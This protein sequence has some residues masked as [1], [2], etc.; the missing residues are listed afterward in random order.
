MCKSYR[1]MMRNADAFVVTLLSQA[2]G[3]RAFSRERLRIVEEKI[4][5]SWGKERNIRMSG[6]M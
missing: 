3:T 5:V 2:S 1:M 6:E 4:F